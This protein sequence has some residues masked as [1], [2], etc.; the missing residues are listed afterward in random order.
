MTRLVTYMMIVK[1]DYDGSAKLARKR[2]SEIRGVESTVRV[3]DRNPDNRQAVIECD[4]VRED[5]SS[6]VQ[7]LME[8][9]NTIPKD[10]PYPEGAILYWQESQA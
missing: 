8:W 10:P 6:F 1:T 7:A 2:T 9:N 5:E 4:V 3:R